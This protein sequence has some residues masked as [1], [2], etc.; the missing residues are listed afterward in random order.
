MDGLSRSVP[1]RCFSTA[2]GLVPS[3]GPKRALELYSDDLSAIINAAC[4]YARTGQKEQALE[5]LERLFARGWVKRDWID[6][7]P[8]YDSLRDDPRFKKLVARLK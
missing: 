3:N 7:D 8:D 6:H 2:R 4:L 5:M 1:W